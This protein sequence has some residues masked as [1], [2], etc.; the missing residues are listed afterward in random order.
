MCVHSILGLAY[1]NCSQYSEWDTVIDVTQCQSIELMAL[2]DVLNDNLDILN[3][4]T[5]NSTRDLTI[6]FDI[7]EVESISRDVTDL[8]TNVSTPI[9]PNDIRTTNDIV[10]SLIRYVCMLLLQ[11][12]L[13]DNYTT[14]VLYY[15]YVVKLHMR[16]NANIRSN[17]TSAVG[18]KGLAG[19]NSFAKYINSMA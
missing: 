9:L 7:T 13:I 14:D 15:N 5:N 17:V 2:N 3:D 8:T 18:C 6:M 10:N 19:T 1:R 11:L 12:P 16:P 4:N